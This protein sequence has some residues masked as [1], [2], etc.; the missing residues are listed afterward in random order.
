MISITALASGLFGVLVGALVQFYFG[1][2]LARHQV[3]LNEKSALYIDLFKQL[4][5]LENDTICIQNLICEAQIYASDEVLEILSEIRPNQKVDDKVF[6]DL[7]VAFRKELQPASK[8]RNL[9][10]FIYDRSKK[11]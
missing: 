1:K 10:V 5:N 6:H 9:S 8:A 4:R 7:L 3:Q 11:T 2:E